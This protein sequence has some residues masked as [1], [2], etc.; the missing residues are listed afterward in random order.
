MSPKMRSVANLAIFSLLLSGCSAPNKDAERCED[1]QLVLSYVSLL[2][3]LSLNGVVNEM[4]PELINKTEGQLKTQFED[5]RQAYKS[6]RSPYLT[7]ILQ[8][9]SSAG[10]ELVEPEPIDWS[11]LNLD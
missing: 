7:P 5:V 3:D 4:L 11:G 8:I 9:C 2:E 10:V 6:G 1:F